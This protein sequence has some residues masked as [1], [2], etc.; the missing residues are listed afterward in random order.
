MRNWDTDAGILENQD[1]LFSRTDVVRSV[2]LLLYE[3]LPVLLLIVCADTSGTC[4]D[5]SVA[6]RAKQFGIFMWAST[7]R[8]DD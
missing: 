6:R 7:N 5:D 8:V 2:K 4:V 3:P 1:L